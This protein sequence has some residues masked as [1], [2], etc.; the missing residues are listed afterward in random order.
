MNRLVAMLLLSLLAA[1][2]LEAAHDD[3]DPDHGHEE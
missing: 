3:H 1:C 2:G